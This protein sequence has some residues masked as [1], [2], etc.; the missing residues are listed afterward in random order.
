MTRILAIIIALAII[1][2]LALSSRAAEATPDGRCKG[3]RLCGKVKVVNS[4]PDLKVQVVDR[5]PDLK[6]KKVQ[7]FAD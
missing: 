1:A 7:S 2:A 3:I 5:F 4:F 6:V